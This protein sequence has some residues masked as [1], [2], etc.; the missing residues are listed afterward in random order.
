MVL[1]GTMSKAVLLSG[2]LDFRP[3]VEALVRQGVFVEIWY[4]RDSIAEDLPGAADFGREL[5]F[6]QLYS[7]NTE[8]F[9]RKHRIPDDRRIHSASVR[10]GQLVRTGSLANWEWPVELYKWQGQ[11]GRQQFELWIGT[12]EL[13]SNRNW[14]RRPRPDRPLRP[15]SVQPHKVGIGR[16][17]DPRDAR[18]RGCCWKGLIKKP[19]VISSGRL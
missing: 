7:W 13:E 8:A 2:D 1:N 14:R 9:Q 12:R 3:V 5:R 4:H 10:S 15:G 11:G 6:R 16:A 19:Q 17:Q 18:S